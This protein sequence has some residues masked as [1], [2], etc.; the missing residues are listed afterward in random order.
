[1]QGVTWD[2]LGHYIISQSNDRTCKVYG[3]RP[4]ALSKK[5]PQAPASSAAMLREFVLMN[6]IS[7]RTMDVAASGGQEGA[8]CWVGGWMGGAPLGITLMNQNHGLS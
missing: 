5:G 7:K 1:M 4:P 3:P 8:A 2:P 6:S